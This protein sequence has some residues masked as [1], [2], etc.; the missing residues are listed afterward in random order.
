MRGRKSLRLTKT[1][2]ERI[3][4][5]PGRDVLR[6]DDV[7]PSFGV[8]VKPSGVRS[9]IVQYRNRAGRTR[10][11][12]IGRH[13]LFMVD[14]ARKAAR[15]VL[16]AAADGQ[17]P[18]G[19]RAEKQ[20]T[21]TIADLGQRYL[22]E[23][24]RP[25]KKPSSVKADLCNLKN[26]ILPA[27]GRR[28][29]ADVSRADVARLHHSMRGTPG[30]ANRTLALL[31]KMFNLAERWELRPD[32]TN[33]CRH[34]ERYRERKIERFL[35]DEELARLGNVL[36][37]ADRD[38]F[39]S[40]SAVAAIRLLIFTG[41]RSSEILSLRWENVD[42]QRRLLRLPDSKTGAR[43]VPLNA[44]ALAVLSQLEGNGLPWVLP[45]RRD[46]SHLVNLSKPW[47]SIRKLARLEGLRLHDLRHSFASVGAS[48]G[49]GLPT[50]GKLLGHTQ[51]ATTQR[52]AHLA[53]D[54]LR[55]ASEAI[56]A[57]LENAMNG[58]SVV[59]DS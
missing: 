9:Y 3:Q 50:I 16:L 18:A 39:A 45:G 36:E 14:Q 26:H 38:G 44:P 13:G 49:L 25:K 4:P 41:C 52:Y 1:S 6:W 22:D 34:V 35:S 57:H 53:D 21:L 24:A 48:S 31:S 5:E 20:P 28:E 46:G 11:I 2:V 29:I 55:K 15:R 40:C 17:D 54:P 58:L 33:P 59:V 8:R 10:R 7:L 42:Q 27:L 12:T 51:A 47:D 23:H 43:S 56:A 30:G 32:G 19:A 37:R